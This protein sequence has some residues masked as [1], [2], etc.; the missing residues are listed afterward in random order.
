MIVD[1]N[2]E[3]EDKKKAD[4]ENEKEIEK[5]LESMTAEDG[6]EECEVFSA[7]DSE[8]EF[9]QASCVKPLGSPVKRKSNLCMGRSRDAP[10]TPSKRLDLKLESE[11]CKTNVPVQPFLSRFKRPAESSPC[12]YKS[13]CEI[14]SPNTYGQHRENPATNVLEDDDDSF[15]N[16]DLTGIEEDAIIQSQ[17]QNIKSP[18]QDRTL[19]ARQAFKF[20]RSCDKRNV[21]HLT[22][23][24]HPTEPIQDSPMNASPTVSLLSPVTKC[25]E[26]SLNLGGVTDASKK[27]F[28][29]FE[30][31]EGD[32]TLD[33]SDDD[34]RKVIAMSILEQTRLQVEE[35]EFEEAISNS[36]T[37]R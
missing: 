26:N 3:I 25:L 16:L 20:G 30:F 22:V 11:M 28:E 2:K 8:E 6:E 27:L 21:D 37:Q 23:F 36:Q 35:R 9:T 4:E 33:E 19:D 1:V 5:A 29:D 14:D 13:K 18:V 7:S 17:S 12:S 34:M 24:R 31:D 10:V 32:I 15:D